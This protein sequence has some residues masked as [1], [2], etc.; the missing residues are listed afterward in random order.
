VSAASPIALEYLGTGRSASCPIID[1]HGHLGP[2]HGTFMPA[3]PIEQM[4]R[5]L[6]KCGVKR[7]VCSH[8]TAMAYDMDLG[9][10]LLLDVLAAYPREFLGYWVINP[11]CHHLD[12]D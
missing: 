12:S 1:M 4:R 10:R 3:A 2:F 8:H 5:E 7:I 9:N 11:N 6:A